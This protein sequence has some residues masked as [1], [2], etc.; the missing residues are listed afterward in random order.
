MLNNLFSIL[1][2]A[3]IGYNQGEYAFLIFCIKTY[4]M[5]SSENKV[6]E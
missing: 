4:L 5:L 3:Y 6:I 2:Y 1:I